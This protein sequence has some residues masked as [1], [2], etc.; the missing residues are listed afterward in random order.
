MPSAQPK[1]TVLSAVVSQTSSQTLIHTFVVS[2]MSASLIQT[3]Q[4]HLHVGMKNVSIPV[5]VPNLL[6]VLLEITEECVRASLAMKEI[7]MALLAHQFLNQ[8]K[9]RDAKKIET[10]PV[11]KSA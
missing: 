6:I 7:L 5:S 4:L 3:V 9:M 11:R 1:I 10:V 2:S 8:F